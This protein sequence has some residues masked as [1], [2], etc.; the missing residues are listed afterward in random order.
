[1]TFVHAVTLAVMALLTVP[2]HAF[3]SGMDAKPRVQKQSA[4]LADSKHPFIASGEA[5]LS[6]E[7]DALQT[8][9]QALIQAGNAWTSDWE[10]VTFACADAAEAFEKVSGYEKVADDLQDLSLIGGCSSVGPPSSV[11]NLLDLQRHFKE[12]A[13]KTGN[14][15]FECISDAFGELAR[16]Y[17]S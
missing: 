13:E 3:L 9:A 15:E 17:T 2:T 14:E 1:M 4:N 10:E 5:L 12:L 6:L 16:E 8:P 7:D 11:P